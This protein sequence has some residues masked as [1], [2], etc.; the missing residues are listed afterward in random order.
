MSYGPEYTYCVHGF[1]I[2]LLAPQIL[3]VIIHLGFDPEDNM[4]YYENPNVKAT[5]LDYLS[6]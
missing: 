6:L 2:R 1:Q 3:H 5:G 4:Q